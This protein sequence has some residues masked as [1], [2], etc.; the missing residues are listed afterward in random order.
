MSTNM[1]ELLEQ[2]HLSSGDELEIRI[3]IFNGKQ[4]TSRITEN[5]YNIILSKLNN[6][7]NFTYT[8]IDQIIHVYNNKI[9]AIY[10]DDSVKIIQK[11]PKQYIDL[12]S[13]NLRIALASEMEL[14]KVP[15]SKYTIKRRKRYTFY[16]HTGMYKID[17]TIDTFRFTT[18]YQC[19]IE[20]LKK[21]S[22]NDLTNMIN[23][24]P[25]LIK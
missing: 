24:I 10:T 3:G 20:Y 8:C 21:P 13:Q 1:S 23:N 19:E 15:N 4:F 2:F 6:N 11:I 18:Q 16:Q 9:R 22:L 25:T 7:R 14:N 5:V 12:P 17:L